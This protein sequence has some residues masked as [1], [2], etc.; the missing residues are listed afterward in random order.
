VATA[1]GRL[2]DL[3]GARDGHQ[4]ALSMRLAALGEEHPDTLASMGDLAGVLR[5]TGAWSAWGP[6]GTLPV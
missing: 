6:V 2:G 3:E 1:L 4:D 5:P